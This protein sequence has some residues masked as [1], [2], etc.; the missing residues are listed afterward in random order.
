MDTGTNHAMA[1]EAKSSMGSGERKYLVS[2]N[3]LS[4]AGALL[5]LACLL[6]PWLWV[7]EGGVELGSSGMDALDHATTRL[8]PSMTLGIVLFTAGSMIA[9]A[10]PSGGGV[11]TVGLAMFYSEELQ[12]EEKIALLE[13]YDVGLSCG[14][15]LAAFATALVLAGMI[16]PT[17]YGHDGRR[18]W[19]STRALT[20]ARVRI[21]DGRVVRFGWA[22][23]R[24]L[25]LLPKRMSARRAAGVTATI[26][27]ACALLAAAFMQ[28]DASLTVRLDDGVILP[29]TGLNIGRTPSDNWE[30]SSISVSDG[31][32]TAR[33]NMSIHEWGTGTWSAYVFE[34][35]DLGDAVVRLTVVD[36]GGDNDKTFGD[37]VV[38][39]AV[40]G[41]AFEEDVTYTVKISSPSEPPTYTDAT[42]VC[43]TATFE[44][45]RDGDI[46]W[47]IE[48]VVRSYVVYED[49]SDILIAASLIAV[50]AAVCLG[51]YAVLLGTATRR[52]T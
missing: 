13:G 1:T 17:D 49:E 44:L 42:F 7:G 25:S 16:S 32:D 14:F 8:A 46:K 30:D 15:F 12:A 48:T 5:G 18:P 40:N 2:V 26:T 51:I 22:T 29:A 3:V 9:L 35:R 24:D 39:T 43:T 21:E 23:L 19:W 28:E 33:W 11:Q 27:L 50:V 10:A 4:I 6:L 37:Y 52:R 45:T 38:L 20:C 36:W 41:T 47:D 31:T 34:P